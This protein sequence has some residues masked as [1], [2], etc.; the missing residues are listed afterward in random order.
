MKIITKGS[1]EEFELEASQVV[2]KL[3]WTNIGL[4]HI[5]GEQTTPAAQL[6]IPEPQVS[7]TAQPPPQ[8]SIPALLENL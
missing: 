5:T 1:E 8:N 4:G 3:A 7:N 6:R 2:P